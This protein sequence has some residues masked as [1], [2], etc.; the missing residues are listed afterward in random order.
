[1]VPRR[2]AQAKPSEE[3]VKDVKTSNNVSKVEYEPAKEEEK[4][5]E[6]KEE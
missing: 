5:D 1:M 3:K 2:T 4:K 6:K